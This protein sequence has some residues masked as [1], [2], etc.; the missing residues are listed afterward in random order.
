MLSAQPFVSRKRH[1]PLA[2][3]DTDPS[4][5]QTRMPR[6]TWPPQLAWSWGVSTRA[7]RRRSPCIYL[8]QYHIGRELALCVPSRLRHEQRPHCKQ[9]H[10]QNW[11]RDRTVEPF[12]LIGDETYLANAPAVL[13]EKA[14]III[15][16]EQE[17]CILHVPLHRGAFSQAHCFG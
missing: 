9:R 10:A 4:L 1:R 12:A 8:L 14:E 3:S 13:G 7:D 6:I 2:Y 11:N 16:L 15:G 5:S 17:R